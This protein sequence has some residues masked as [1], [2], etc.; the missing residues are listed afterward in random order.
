MKNWP[1]ITWEHVTSGESQYMA[2]AKLA[3][4]SSETHTQVAHH[5]STIFITSR[6]DFLNINLGLQR[7]KIFLMKVCDFQAWN[8]FSNIFLCK[9]RFSSSSQNI[10]VFDTGWTGE[11]WDRDTNRSQ[12]LF[13]LSLSTTLVWKF[14]N[15]L[16]KEFINS[17]HFDG[18]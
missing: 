14:R 2:Q 9:I 5:F 4:Y 7:M 3:F 10:Q 1:G 17:S 11:S 15:Y 6:S 13:I 16:L 8:R 18:Y 12:C